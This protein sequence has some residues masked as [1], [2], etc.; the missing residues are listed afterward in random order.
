MFP[1]GGMAWNV[2]GGV[3]LTWD[4]FQGLQT[5]GQVREADAMIESVRARRDALVNEVW[6]AVQRAA[7]GVR[8]AH[9]S[10]VAAEEALVAA[11]QRLRLADGRY[12]AG[13]GSI[14]EL[15]DAE[16]APP[17][18]ALSAASPPIRAIDRPRRADP[19]AG[20]AVGRQ[21]L[22]PTRSLVLE[23]SRARTARAKVRSFDVDEHP[24]LFA[25]LRDRCCAAGQARALG[26]GG[27]DFRAR[28]GSRI[29]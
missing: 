9:E 3:Q 7:A 17:T 28:V 26:G 6:V 20:A 24:L 29:G 2:W 8:A 23:F 5:R 21:P 16:V 19:G 14:I 13:V 22:G 12:A 4:V 11:N 27:E 10:L 25:P 1:Y 18:P 15:S